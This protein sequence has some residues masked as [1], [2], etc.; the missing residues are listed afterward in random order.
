MIFRYFSFLMSRSFSNIIYRIQSGSIEIIPSQT[1]PNSFYEASIT[2]I[3]KQDKNISKKDNYKPA[4]LM[5]LDAK[6]LNKIM[7]NRIQQHIQKIIHLD[8]VCFIPRMQG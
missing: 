1:L 7:A 3:P 8:Q 6:V 2:L 4:S 5:N